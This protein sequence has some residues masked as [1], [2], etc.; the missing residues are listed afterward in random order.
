LSIFLIVGATGYVN[1]DSASDELAPTIRK[2]LNHGA[3]VALNLI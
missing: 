3:N 2:I 1:K